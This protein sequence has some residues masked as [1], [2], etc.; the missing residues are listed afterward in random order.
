M[1]RS[2]VLWPKCAYRT[3]LMCLCEMKCE[4]TT[5]LHADV[6]E[7]GAAI[8]YCQKL[9]ARLYIPA[10]QLHVLSTQLPALLLLFDEQTSKCQ[11]DVLLCYV[12]VIFKRV[13][14]KRPGTC[15]E[16]ATFS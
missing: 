15:A 10:K 16:K 8:G 2:L 5:A 12:T 13:V 7:V 4:A 9:L 6:P 3:A 1:A 14:Q 11:P